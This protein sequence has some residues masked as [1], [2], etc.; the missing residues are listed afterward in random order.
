MRTLS[1]TAI[2]AITRE[3]TPEVFSWLIALSHADMTTLYF[4]DNTETITSG[5]HDYIYYPFSFSPPEDKQQNT[6]SATLSISNYNPVVV[7]ALRAL[8]SSPTITASMVLASEPDTALYGPV[9]FVVDSID[10][11]QKTIA[12]KL[13]EKNVFMYSVPWTIYTAQAFPGLTQ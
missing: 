8:S 9:A 5:G 1:A 12:A 10:I 13:K 4:T 11:S 7:A 6:F 3:T 2:A